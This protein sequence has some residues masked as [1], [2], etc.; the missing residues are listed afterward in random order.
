M[1]RTVGPNQDST[2]EDGEKYNMRNFLL[3]TFYLST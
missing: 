2:T 3:C 1:R